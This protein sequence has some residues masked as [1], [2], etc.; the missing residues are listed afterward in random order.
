MNR[1]QKGASLLSC[2][3][4]QLFPESNRAEED[5]NKRVK[6]MGLPA[7]CTTEHSQA[8]E[9]D[10]VRLTITF[11]TLEAMEEQITTIKKLV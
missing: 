1:P 4:K 6:R 3:H 10:E 9:K 8:F 5:F 2:L 7:S 11:P